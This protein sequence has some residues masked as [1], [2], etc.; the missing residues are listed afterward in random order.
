MP[1]PLTEPRVLLVAS[2]F[3]ERVTEKLKRGAKEALAKKGIAQLEEV[4]VAGSWE[5]PLALQSK[6]QERPYAFAVAIGAIVRGETEHHRYLAQAV[7]QGLMQISL[8]TATPI[9][10]GILTVD[11]AA[12]ALARAGGAKGNYGENAAKSAH[13][14]WKLTAKNLRR[15]K[16]KPKPKKR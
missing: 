1:T 15:P 4:E 7:F 12:Q 11:N 5:I 3:N 10:L 8:A 6:L 2:R 13:A 16:Q 14:L 9:G